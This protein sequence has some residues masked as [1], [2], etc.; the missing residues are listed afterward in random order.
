MK[1][2]LKGFYFIE[3]GAIL[4]FYGHR[5]LWTDSRCMITSYHFILFILSKLFDGLW[6]TLFSACELVLGV[7]GLA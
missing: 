2:R 3:P 1:E 7:Q 6:S 4:Q 5:K